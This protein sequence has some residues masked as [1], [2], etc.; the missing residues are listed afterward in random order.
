MSATRAWHSGGVS[1]DEFRFLQDNAAEVGLPWDGPPPVRR[2]RLDLESEQRISAL[3]WG[4][5]D[6]E[7]AV[8]HGGA[9][10][11]HTWDTVALALGRP[12]V[13]IDLP[14]HGHSSWR[15]DARY[16]PRTMADDVGEAIARLAP[17]AKAVVG[18]SLGGLTTAAVA[19]R[20]SEVVRRL[21]LV[22]VTPGVDEE[23]ARAITDFLAGPESFANFEDM[24]AYTMQHNPTRSESSLRRGVTHNAF[25][26]R[27]GSW[28]WRWDRRM[29][30]AADP[31]AA[32][33]IP[34]AELWEEI[35][36]TTQP[37]LLVRGGASPVVG[38][39]DVAELLRRRPD[40]RIAVVDGAGHSIQGDRPVELA[41][42]LADFAD[43]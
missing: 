41:A 28:V 1:D 16:D 24:L 35:G 8:V 7:L 40:A 19:V 37:L 15:D 23:G 36:A 2:E 9:Q 21:A 39:D 33:R 13:A 11:A 10:N 17:A 5:G 25:M 43:A 29:T 4:D 14:G 26:R 38:D 18:M 42:I 12:L 31:T 27:N 32:P 3:V 22:D 20:R 30:R 6:P 34:Q